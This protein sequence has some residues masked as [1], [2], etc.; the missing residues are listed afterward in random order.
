MSYATFEDEEAQLP[1]APKRTCSIR[2]VLSVALVVTVGLV[3]AAASGTR[4]ATPL[5]YFPWT[6]LPEP[7]VCVYTGP[8]HWCFTEYTGPDREANCQAAHG[9]W[10]SLISIAA[11]QPLCQ[12]DL[13]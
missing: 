10:M 2:S 3:Y 8:G 4:Q 9:I 13:C 12:C 6:P 5:E 11:T 1:P 7:Y